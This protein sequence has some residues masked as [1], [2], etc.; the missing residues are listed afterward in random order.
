MPILGENFYLSVDKKFEKKIL[1]ADGI[2]Q[3]IEV[4]EIK[5]QIYVGEIYY[6]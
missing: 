4:A 5:A 6:K 2:N 1:E 3:E